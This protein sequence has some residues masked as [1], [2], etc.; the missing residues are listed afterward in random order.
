MNCILLA[1]VFPRC[2]RTSF[3]SEHMMFLQLARKFK[4]LDVDGSGDI[5]FTEFV[6]M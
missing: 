4:Q 5:D 1:S 6:A 2:K 3:T